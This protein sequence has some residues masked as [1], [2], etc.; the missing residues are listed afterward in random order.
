MEL[1]YQIMM[2]LSLAACAGFR[3]W[4]PLF[5]MGGMARLGGDHA[6]VTLHP[7]MAFLAS[8]TMLIIFGIASALEFAGDKVI[9]IDHF[10]D[11]VGTVARP[12]A[13]T[14]LASSLLTHMDLTTALLLGLMVGGGTAFTMHAAKATVRAKSSIFAP[15]HGGMGNAA[16][17][18]GE[19]VLSIGGSFLA[20]FAPIVAFVAALMM[21]AVAGVTVYFGFKAGRK[22]FRSISKRTVAPPAIPDAGAVAESNIVAQRSAS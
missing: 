1:A 4:L 10:L 18:F 9:A 21:L 3:A 7:A 16:L 8:D 13:G 12:V 14:V 11:A 6:H 17:S 15:F 2:G 20:I 19:D 5:V 22:L